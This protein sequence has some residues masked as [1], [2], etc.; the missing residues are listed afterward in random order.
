MRGIAGP[1]AGVFLVVGGVA[2]VFLVG[3]VVA[4]WRRAVARGRLGCFSD[5]GMPVK[6]CRWLLPI[7]AVRQPRG[8]QQFDKGVGCKRQVRCR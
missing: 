3:F 7:S 5:G 8:A 6:F 1:F 2:A 4:A